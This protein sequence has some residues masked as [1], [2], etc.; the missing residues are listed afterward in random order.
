MLTWAELLHG[1]ELAKFCAGDFD[2]PTVGPHRNW[3]GHVRISQAKSQAI[4]VLALASPAIGVLTMIVM[5]V[6]MQALQLEQR[7]RN[8]LEHDDKSDPGYSQRDRLS[9]R[10]KARILPPSSLQTPWAWVLSG[11]KGPR[12]LSPQT[13]EHPP[14]FGPGVRHRR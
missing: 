13:L 14:R 11:R 2:P 4:N 3:R 8:A 9:A 7:I 12:E 1:Y 5:N 6:A 10:T